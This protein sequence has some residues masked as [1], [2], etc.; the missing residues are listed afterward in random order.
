VVMIGV[1]IWQTGFSSAKSIQQVNEM[2]S[3][4]KV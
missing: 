4:F 2:I 1:G 3:Q